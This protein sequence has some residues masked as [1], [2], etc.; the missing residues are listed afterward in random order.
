MRL[1]L[2]LVN[3]LLHSFYVQSGGVVLLLTTQ[4]QLFCEQSSLQLDPVSKEPSHRHQHQ[5]PPLK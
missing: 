2:T 4:V 1:G 3:V 5:S